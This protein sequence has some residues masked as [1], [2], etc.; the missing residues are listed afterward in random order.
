MLIAQAELESLVIVTADDAL[1][2]YGHDLI[3]ARR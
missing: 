3:D 2:Q 1:G